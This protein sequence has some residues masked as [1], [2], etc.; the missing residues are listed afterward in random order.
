MLILT[1]V[2]QEDISHFRFKLAGILLCWK[3]NTASS[4]QIH[5]TEATNSNDVSK[6]ENLDGQQETKA[7]EPL[8]E[9]TKYESLML[10]LSKMSA[11]E[12]IGGLCD[13]IKSIT[14]AKTLE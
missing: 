3:T 14:C 2:M 7:S 9:E 4:T 6:L 5:A 8:P 13:Y 11:N 12:L 1:N 10:V